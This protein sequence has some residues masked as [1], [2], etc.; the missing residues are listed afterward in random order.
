MPIWAEAPK[1]SRRTSGRVGD[2][3]SLHVLGDTSAALNQLEALLA[4]PSFLSGALLRTNPTWA[5]LRGNPR[6]E[7]L[8]NGS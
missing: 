5:P 7:R 6:F 2:G 1:P 3:H 8:V 4:G